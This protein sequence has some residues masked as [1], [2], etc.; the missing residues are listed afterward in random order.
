MNNRGA[1]SSRHVGARNRT[2]RGGVIGHHDLGRLENGPGHIP[3][4]P[5]PTTTSRAEFAVLVDLD[6]VAACGAAIR[7]LVPQL[8][9]GLPAGVG[10]GDLRPGGHVWRERQ[11]TR[12]VGRRQDRGSQLI[13]HRPP[14]TLQLEERGHP[15]DGVCCHGFRRTTGGDQDRGKRDLPHRQATRGIAEWYGPRRPPLD[16]PFG[17][18]GTSRSSGASF[19]NPTKQ[20]PALAGRCGSASATA[21]PAST[22]R[23]GPLHGEAE[24]Y[25]KAPLMA[26]AGNSD[27]WM[28]T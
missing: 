4:E 7:R 9:Y 8:D 13:G 23:R 16:W 6:V 20:R 21:L 25:R 3:E 5:G 22:C 10:N 19:E 26:P 11:A 18:A 28:L 1:E 15:I 17:R 24:G 27:V 12:C 2:A 14:R